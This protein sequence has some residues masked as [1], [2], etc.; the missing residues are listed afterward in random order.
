MDQGIKFETDYHFHWNHGL[1]S[2]FFS[3]LSFLQKKILTRHFGDSYDELDYRVKR[4][5]G[6]PFLRGVT[7]RN[8]AENFNSMMSYILRNKARKKNF[9]V[10]DIGS[11]FSKMATI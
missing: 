6:H 7:N 1:Q 2:S 4:N 9:M 8:I 3:G 11:K 10:I 5:E